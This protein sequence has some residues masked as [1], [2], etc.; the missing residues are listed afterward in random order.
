MSKTNTNIFNVLGI[1]KCIVEKTAV[2]TYTV[3]FEYSN[4]NDSI[5][6]ILVVLYTVYIG[7]V[8]NE[9]MRMSDGSMC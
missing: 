4:W 6:F 7:F 1:R 8:Q 9:S 3:P 5:T 2:W